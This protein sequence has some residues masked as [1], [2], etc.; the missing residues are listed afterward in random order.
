MKSSRKEGPKAPRR[1]LTPKGLKAGQRLQ[2]P[3]FTDSERSTLPS[4]VSSAR[5]RMH[6]P[7]VLESLYQDLRPI[8]K[9]LA[10]L[11]LLQS[12]LLQWNYANALAE[13][14]DSRLSRRI[15]EEV[16]EH[17]L[18]L[19]QLLE[20]VQKE[21]SRLKAALQGQLL[22]QALSMETEALEPNEEDVLKAAEYLIEVQTATKGAITRVPLAGDAEELQK[23]LSSAGH[24][25]DR[26]T[27]LIEEEAPSTIELIQPSQR[28][29]EAVAEEREEIINSHFLLNT[30]RK[31]YEE[32]KEAIAVC[33]QKETS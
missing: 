19:V 23:S 28:L 6:S 4:A 22:D 11:N 18:Q 14:T 2:S 13:R 21:E 8:H 26:V 29:A 16:Y 15:E 10:D 33:A 27:V 31:L 9:E 25:L 3:N 20:E 12:T 17:G 32:E 24:S 7:K 30:L 5:Q 1:L